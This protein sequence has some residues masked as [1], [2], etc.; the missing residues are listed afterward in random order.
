M[1]YIMRAAVFRALFMVV[2]VSLVPA[3][4]S[5]AAAQRKSDRSVVA[6]DLRPVYAT[7]A[8]V[9]EGK[10]IASA[11][12]SCYRCHGPNGISSIKGVPNLAGQ[13]PVYLYAKLRAYQAGTRGDRGMQAAVKYLNDD[14]L[15][16]LAAYYASLDPAEPRAAE[17]GKS[18]AA[19][20]DP[21]AAAKAAAAT[22]GGCHGEDGVSKM[23]GTPSLVG[24]DP[25]YF[26]AA[27]KAYKT[28]QRKNDVMKSMV[29]AVSDSDV[30]QIALYYALQKPPK[31]KPVA[32]REQAAGK[33]AA[34]ACAGCHGEHGVSASPA[35]PSLA[36]QDPQYLFDAL[37]AYKDGS[38][39]EET[40][41]G[42]ASG[43]SEKTMKDLGRYY[44]AQAAQAPK[45]EKPLSAAQW[46]QRCNRCHGV[47]GNSMDLRIPALAA[48]HPE[49]LQ[50]ALN[51]Y[52]S[53]AR[54]VDIMHA[55]ASGL[56]DADIAALAAHYA[57]QKARAL[58]YVTI[59]CK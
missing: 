4:Q 50:K 19:D 23:P 42:I 21:M 58:V 7:P 28:G 1:K 45:V 10:H 41:K 20:R 31:P 53:G 3:H 55:M 24:L 27:V 15:V 54:K 14:A 26:A 37:R 38:R 2:A 32:A 17:S 56:S 6:D 25:T 40:M 22:C 35:T 49:Y 13:R 47:N 18:A 46:A 33:A 5:A 48:Q 44:A 52:K 16:K 51:A 11:E 29:A 59:P 57:R 12:G 36:G 34:G 30:K 43:L 9:A 8:D 39:K